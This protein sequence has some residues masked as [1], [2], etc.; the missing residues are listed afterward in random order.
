M[1]RHQLTNA[2]ARRAILQAGSGLGLTALLP[3]LA[4][5]QPARNGV[6]KI[7]VL[8][9]DTSDPHRHTGSIAV[10]QVYVETLTSIADDGTVKPFLAESW[11]LS[12]DGRTYSFT[13]REGVKFHDGKP[14]TSADVKANFERVRDKVRGGWLTSAMKSATEIATPDARTLVLVLKSPY[15]PLL[16]LLSELWILSPDSIGW[17]ETISKPIGT[18]PFMFGEWVPKQRLVAPAFTAYWQPGLPKAAAVE[19]DLRDAEDNSLPL[20][21]G[22][23]HIGRVSHEAAAGLAKDP[24]LEIQ[25]FKDTTWWF[26]SFNNRRPRPPFDN[27]KVREAVSYMLD[28]TAY[29]KF[30]AG[31]AAVVTNQMAAPGNF[32]WDKALHDNDRHAKP[33]PA[34]ARAMLRELGIDPA[35]VQMRIVSWQEEYTQIAVQAMRSLGFQVE[36][37]ALDDIGAQRRLGQYDWDL[38][39]MSSG[40]RADIFLRY[41]RLMSDGPNPVLWGGVQDL[42]FD[43][44]VNAAVATVDDQQR[45]SVY[46][47]AWERAMDRYYTI[48]VGHAPNALGV[49]RD[50]SGFTTGFTWS[51]HRVDG[52]LAFTSVTRAS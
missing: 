39:P 26:W 15:A 13:L 8:G 40:P 34:R 44:L 1:K 47:D 36:H 3:R 10:Q 5:A 21:A 46:L 28:K 11:T 32:Y 17:N 33:D 38:A 14:M 49:R 9:L 45:R 42:E 4:T 23:L 31:D 35:K 37:L 25:H 16:N 12:P 6:I 48:V 27:P 41:V 19:F 20:R 52:G 50:T 22:D 18:G 2:F 30:V 7:A 29:M 51:Q 43:R 24:Q